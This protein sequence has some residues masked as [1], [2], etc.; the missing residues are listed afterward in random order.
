MISFDWLDIV[1]H[2]LSTEHMWAELSCFT[3]SYQ[4]NRANKV[5]GKLEIKR[6]SSFHSCV[7]VTKKTIKTWKLKHGLLLTRGHN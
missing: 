2:E 7:N 6:E 3:K 1:Q 4:S 5:I